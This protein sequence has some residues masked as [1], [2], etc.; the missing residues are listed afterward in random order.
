MTELKAPRIAAG[1]PMRLAGIRQ[2]HTFADATKTI[3]AQW[4]AFRQLGRIAGA[5]T[6]RRSETIDPSTTYGVICGNDVAAQTFDYMCAIA[7]TDFESLP[8]DFARISIQAQQYAV[9]THEGHISGLQATWNS[10]WNEWLPASG[11]GPADVPDFE[12][13]DD[14]FDPKTGMG[15]V[16]IW[17]P[18]GD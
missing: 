18:I 11:Y 16:E 1:Q 3:P 13:Y 15:L 9:F 6:D 17:F 12:V 4:E 7:V 8:A 10:I 5:M 14:R 2:Q